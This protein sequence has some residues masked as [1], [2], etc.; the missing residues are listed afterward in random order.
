[1][2]SSFLTFTYEQ[3]CHVEES[4]PTPYIHCELVIF[5]LEDNA[6]SMRVTVILFFQCGCNT[7]NVYANI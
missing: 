6:V 5:L 7:D 4:L 2:K 3:V 1:M